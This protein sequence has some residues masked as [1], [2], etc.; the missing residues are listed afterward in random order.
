LHRLNDL[1]T[2]NVF[3]IEEEPMAESPTGIRQAR[4][5]NLKLSNGP[6]GQVITARVPLDCSEEEYVS[7]A[8]ATYSM[9]AR[10]TGVHCAS[11]RIKA[12]TEDV[13]ADAVRVE[14]G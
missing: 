4:H 8:R 6:D 9:I 2:V 14:L 12:V 5:A 3:K 13:Y 7:V 10:L 11:G 1:V